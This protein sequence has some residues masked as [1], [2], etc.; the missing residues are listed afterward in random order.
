MS[1][2]EIRFK[3]IRPHENSRHT[4]FEEMC[5]QLAALEKRPATAVFFRKGRG[6]DAGV[7]CFTRFPD[8]KERGWQAKYVDRWDTSLKSQLDESIRTALNKHPKLAE[9]VV[10]LPF[11][12]PDARTGR[13]LSP[14]GHW[15]RWSNRWVKTAKAEG[16]QL[17]IELWSASALA[18]RLSRDDPAYAGRLLYWFDQEALTPSWFRQQFEKSRAALGSRYV[19]ASNVELPIRRGIS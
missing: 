9:Y 11:D 8:G 3:T 1:L 18:E 2:P 17:S 13:G 4:G 19:P 10:C 15:Q 12:L 5:C 14:I 16:R 6:G 7:E